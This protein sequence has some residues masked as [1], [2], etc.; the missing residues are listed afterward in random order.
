VSRK[1]CLNNVG[2]TGP[3]FIQPED[4]AQHA[5][6]GCDHLWIVTGT[7]TADQRS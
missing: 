1:H 3:E 5:L 4:L 6:S 2:L 7:A